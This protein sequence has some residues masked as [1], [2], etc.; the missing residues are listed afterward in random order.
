MRPPSF[1]ALRRTSTWTVAALIA[2]GSQW[3]GASNGRAGIRS[4]PDKLRTGPG[5][6]NHP[7]GVVPSAAI[8]IP[9][10]WPLA[11]DGSLTCLTCHRKIPPLEGASQA[12]LR[13]SADPRTDS[14]DFCR[15]CH[16][17]DDSSVSAASQH[18]M[19]VGEAHISDAEYSLRRRATM[20]S[21]SRRCLECH[22]GVNATEGA[23]STA[24]NRGPGS[25][26][27]PR[28]NH[29]VGVPYPARTVR[30]PSSAFRPPELLPASIRLP[31]GKVSC[32]SCH[33][34]Y[35]TSRGRLT[36]PI[37]GSALCF[38]CHDMN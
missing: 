38:V 15:N 11:P 16:G 31:E 8:R 28:R 33:D 22:D 5:T 19:A 7:V 30:G 3:T 25:V 34:L 12:F 14:L 21:R 17:H 13:G 9:G 10:G 29:P 24:W 35:A 36:A 1:V 4:S 32:V 26:G 27:D 6:S 37:E 18:W 2:L 23:T 20:D